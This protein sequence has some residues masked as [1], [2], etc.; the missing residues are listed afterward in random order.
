MEKKKKEKQKLEKIPTDKI[1]RIPTDK[2]KRL[3]VGKQIKPYKWEAKLID[4][5]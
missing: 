3:V 1:E 4:V 5:N 2:L